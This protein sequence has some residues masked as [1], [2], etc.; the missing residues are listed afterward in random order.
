MANPNLTDS[1]K[2]AFGS[3][4]E[5]MVISCV[6]NQQPCDLNQ[7]F[8]WYFDPFY[9]NCFRFNMGLNRQNQYVDL[10]YATK[11]GKNNGLQ[12]KLYIS[13]PEYDFAMYNS[14]VSSMGAHVF[15]HNQSV[16]PT[17]YTGFDVAVNAETNVA[18]NRVFS[19]R[20]PSPYSDCVEKIDSYESVF[21]QFFIQNKLA[22]SRSQCFNYCY[23]VS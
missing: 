7:S 20:M 18:I 5:Q 19:S 12:L 2:Q 16:L 21:T 8:V 3:T 22:Y 9:G 23:Q 17:F 11:S 6:W 13:Q 1:Q 14:Y 10:L 4:L 15:V